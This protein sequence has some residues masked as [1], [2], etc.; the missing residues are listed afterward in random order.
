MSRNPFKLLPLSSKTVSHLW[1]LWLLP[2]A[3]SLS[4]LLLLSL[5]LS[6]YIHIYIYTY[7]YIYILL[8]LSLAVWRRDQPARKR[9]APRVVRQKVLVRYPSCWRGQPSWLTTSVSPRSS[10]SLSLYLALSLSLSLPIVAAARHLLPTFA[11][12]VSGRGGAENR[13]V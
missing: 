4:I 6:I 3:L 7:I 1:L 10:L 8:S 13:P 5:S 2:L 9:S 11:F 12:R